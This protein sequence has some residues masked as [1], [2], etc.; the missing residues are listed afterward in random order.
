MIKN[1]T[2][3]RIAAFFLIFG[4]LAGATHLYLVNTP[5]KVAII[6][7]TSYEMERYQND[8]YDKVEKLL[9]SRYT[10]FALLSDKSLIFS[11]TESPRPVRS[12]KFYGPD[13]FSLITASAYTEL[14]EA[15]SVILISRSARASDLKSSV[16]NLRVIR[17]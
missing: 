1:K 11:W 17:L 12:L 3:I 14:A 15:D 4:T 10:E 2:V 6:I 5:R 16:R 8:I 7:D 9:K 13:D